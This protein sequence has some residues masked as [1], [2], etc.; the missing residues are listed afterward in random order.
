MRHDRSMQRLYLTFTIASLVFCL[1][2]DRK[3]DFISETSPFVSITVPTPQDGKVAIASRVTRFAEQRGMKTHFV[4]DHF[5]PHEF[6]LSLTRTDLNIIAGNV[7]R[8]DRVHV[9]AYA[10]GAP[11]AAQRTEVDAYLCEVM[12]HRCPRKSPLSTQSGH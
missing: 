10:R 1:G 12:R 11:T 8:S 4:P 7:M 9:T 2:C 3:S 6:T 5:E